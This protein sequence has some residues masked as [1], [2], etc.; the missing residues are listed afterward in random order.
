[1]YT[2]NALFISH[3][4]E[5]LIT[6]N[7]QTKRVNKLIFWIYSVGINW[8]DDVSPFFLEED[9][10][11][12]ESHPHILLLSYRQRLLI[13][14]MSGHGHSHGG[15]SGGHDHDPP[16]RGAEF[17]LYTKIDTE[18]VE[19]LNEVI[20]GSGKLVFKAWDERLDTDKVVNY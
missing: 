10:R 13:Y 15:C 12:H 11:T 7:P 14:W 16:D 9:L 3:L 1:M 20:D 2:G 6:D 18:R 19:C 17:S 8:Y 4:A 5:T